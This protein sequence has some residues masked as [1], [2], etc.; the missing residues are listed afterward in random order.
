MIPFA[1]NRTERLSKGDPRLSLEERYGTLAG[2]VEAVRKATLRAV[3]M[4]FLLQADADALI[5]EAAA[6][7][8]PK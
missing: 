3:S 1:W 8:L 6:I 4:G 5:A 2:Y 7:Q